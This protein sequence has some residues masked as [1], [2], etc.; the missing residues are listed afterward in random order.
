LGYEIS[1]KTEESIMKLKKLKKL[2]I[3][4][5]KTKH[6]FDL[7]HL[8]KL[9]FLI[10]NSRTK[11]IG[12]ENLK[13]LKSLQIINDKKFDLRTLPNGIFE[14]TEIIWK[15]THERFEPFS[16]FGIS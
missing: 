15:Q 13:R 9:E 2:D 10:F 1:A 5:A 3:S 16:Q 4:I 7:G 12:F 6:I 14:K 11:F 8:K